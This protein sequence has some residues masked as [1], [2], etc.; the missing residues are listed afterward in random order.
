V[1]AGRESVLFHYELG[2][3]I[4]QWSNVEAGIASVLVICLRDDGEEPSGP[5]AQ[6]IQSVVAGYEAIDSFRSK[7]SFAN[8]VFR[9]SR[10]GP[11][12]GDEFALAGVSHY[13]CYNTGAARP[14][15][16]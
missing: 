6:R 15:T 5:N 13:E 7:V 16:A 14:A 11:A 1:N 12:N 9:N 2:R 4:S 3:A 8:A 10:L